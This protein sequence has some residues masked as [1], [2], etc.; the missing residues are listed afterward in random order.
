MYKHNSLSLCPSLSGWAEIV[1]KV[2]PGQSCVRAVE[3]GPIHTR[4][5]THVRLHTTP[6]N[7]PTYIPMPLPDSRL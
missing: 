2:D 4:A 5:H 1:P 6:I 7:P 3:V